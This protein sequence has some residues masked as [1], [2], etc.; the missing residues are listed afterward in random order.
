MYA[1]ASVAGRR[2]N[3]RTGRSR[4]FSQERG[5]TV[6]V[7]PQSN[8][9]SDFRMQKRE[10]C[11]TETGSAGDVVE[12]PGSFLVED[13]RS[14]PEGDGPLPHIPLRTRLLLCGADHPVS[15]Q[16]PGPPHVTPAASL[17][18]A[19]HGAG[20]YLCRPS[21]RRTEVACIARTNASAGTNRKSTQTGFG[22]H[23][24]LGTHETEEFRG[25][26]G[27]RGSGKSSGINTLFSLFLS[28]LH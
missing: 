7:F 12:S 18:C 3:L 28:Q 26:P 16:L 21:E 10:P 1:W 9:P 22:S 8:I 2:V 11:K 13:A 19:P 5:K 27:F 15:D 4:G 20:L 25:G 14:A 23:W 24:T 17:T 6:F